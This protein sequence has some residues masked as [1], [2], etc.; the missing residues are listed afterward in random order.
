ACLLAACCPSSAGP[1]AN[2]RSGR[3]P[4]D[5]R[6]EWHMRI[7]PPSR[8]GSCEAPQRRLRL[9]LLEAFRHSPRQSLQH[10]TRL[11]RAHGLQRLDP[12][13]HPHLLLRKEL[14]AALLEQ[15]LQAAAELQALRTRQG[16][17][18]RRLDGLAQHFQL[19]CRLVADVEL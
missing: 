9:R 15:L 8:P 18:E 4:S 2:S 3:A 19:P 7:S 1:G 10:L 16:L 5:R 14:L 13:E 6:P 17:P 11:R 12:A